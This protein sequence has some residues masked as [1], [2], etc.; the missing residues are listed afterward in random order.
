MY[1]VYFLQ[2]IID[3]GYYIGVTSNL[4]KRIYEHNAGLSKSTKSRRPF[5]LVRAEEYSDINTAYRRER[6]LKLKKSA[7]II[8]KI[9]EG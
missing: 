7:K 6:F 9:I 8:K 3:S 4:Q 5:K 1:Y 2:S